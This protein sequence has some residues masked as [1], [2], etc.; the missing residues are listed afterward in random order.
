MR[1]RPAANDQAIQLEN[2]NL[3]ARTYGKSQR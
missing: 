1:P 2:Y 3:T